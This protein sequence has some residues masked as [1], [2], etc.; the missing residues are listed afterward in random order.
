[1]RVFLDME[2]EFNNTCYDAICDALARHG[3]VYTIVRWIRATLEGSVAVATLNCSSV[4]LA[5]SRV[6]QQGVCY[7]HFSGA[8]W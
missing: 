3:N 6:C 4:R 7:Y 5:I 2:G 8:W 1:M